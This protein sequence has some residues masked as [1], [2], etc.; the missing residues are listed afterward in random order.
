MP[1]YQSTPFKKVKG[2]TPGRPAYSA[3]SLNQSLGPFRAYI[4][5]IAVASNVVTLN[6]SYRSGNIPA[7]GDLVSVLGTPIAAANVSNVALASVT[8]NKDT[9]TGTI[10]YAA[11]TPDVGTTACGGSIA[12]AVPEVAEALVQQAYLQFANDGYGFTWSYKC[13]SAPAA[14][15]VQLEGAIR[16]VDAEYAIIGTAQTN[17]NSGIVIAT[18]PDLVNF[19]RINA[20]TVTGGTNP[21]FIAK[22]LNSVRS[23]PMA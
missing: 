12:V 4:T 19:V 1:A 8:I 14:L 21:T 22:I 7:V 18:A 17:V 6:L 23:R 20:T 16:D 5:S 3:G 10:T 2:L 11:T 15:S 9:G 13:P